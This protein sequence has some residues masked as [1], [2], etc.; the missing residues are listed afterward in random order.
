MAS[1]KDDN[2]TPDTRRHDPANPFVAFRR[3]ADEQMASVLHTFFGQPPQSK[4]AERSGFE[5]DLPWIAQAMTDEQ[6]RRLRRLQEE[7]FPSEAY[8]MPTNEFYDQEGKSARGSENEPE[9]CPYR[10]AHQEVPERNRNGPPPELVWKPFSSTND[11]PDVPEDAPPHDSKSWVDDYMCRS[12]YSPLSPERPDRAGEEE[13]KWRQACEIMTHLFR[14]EYEMA[15]EACA[16]EDFR[17][18]FDDETDE[19]DAYDNDEYDHNDALTEQDWY[20]RQLKEHPT[21]FSAPLMTA[22]ARQAFRS[23]LLADG[24]ENPNTATNVAK[25]G[26]TSTLTTTERTTLPDGTVTTKMV[27]KKRFADGREES[28]E[29]THTTHG[30]P[31]QH[32]KQA[33]EPTAQIPK[34][35]KHDEAEKPTEKK[36]AGW[37]WN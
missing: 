13:A 11:E 32:L 21:S 7:P 29:T 8:G 9:R 4:A 6:R 16:N 12:L 35:V 22:M 27:L 14:P 5:D 33:P 26:I 34:A 37:F 15:K 17:C 10:P 24:T 3:F 1:S 30:R 2:T 28:A 31:E 19:E 20:L 18:G 23:E 25:P 36:K